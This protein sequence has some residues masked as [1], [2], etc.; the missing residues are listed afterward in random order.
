MTTDFHLLGE[1]DERLVSRAREMAYAQRT[2]AIPDRLTHAT[3]DLNTATL[4]D[5]LVERVYLLPEREE[6]L[7]RERDNANGLQETVDD[8]IDLIKTSAAGIEEAAS[9][10][11]GASDYPVLMDIARELSERAAQ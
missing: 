2:G 3:R 10:P 4:L 1:T 6:E 11:L 8:L 5:E 9:T 7:A